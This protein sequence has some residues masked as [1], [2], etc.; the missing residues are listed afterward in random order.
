MDLLSRVLV[1]VD[2]SAPSDAAVR[3]A[4][5]L[6]APP[7]HD[8]IRF[9]SVFEREA[10]VDVVQ[11]AAAE[12]ESALGA[13][14]EAAHAAGVDATCVIRTG[15]AV[16][17]ILDEAREWNASCIAIG[18]H[19]RSGIARALLGSCAEG[20]L[21][22]SPLPVL[23]A[24]AA[25]A[26]GED[27]FARIL[28]AVDGS[29]AARRAFEA[30]VALAAERDAELHLLSVVQVADMYATEFELEGFDPDGSMS[31]IYT[32]ARAAVKALA[33]EA[34]AHGAR[35]KPQVLGGADVAERIVRY[36]K[37]QHCEIVLI[38]THGRGG[39]ERA[40]LGSTA[41]G[42]LRSITT[43][44]L[45]FRGASEREPAPHAERVDAVTVPR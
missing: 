29:R 36:A 18:T 6:G 2:G 26:D 30:A 27:R 7:R 24:H 15:L 13:A 9:I 4:L 19:G 40:M 32:E 1:A 21:R 39:I 22:K 31:A 45:A 33:A 8:T 41:E 34:I 10:L 37:A 42:V 16:D 20:V 23:V 14:M 12:F 35:V 38:G 17:A 3:L 5:R 28:C 25:S 44:V 11:G 43:P